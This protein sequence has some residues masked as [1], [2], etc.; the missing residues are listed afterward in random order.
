MSSTPERADLDAFRASIGDLAQRAEPTPMADGERVT[1]AKRVFAERIGVGLA[2]N[3]ESCIHCGMCAEVCHFYES[4]QDPQYAPVRKFELLR[5]Y[6]RRELSPLHWFYKLFVRDITAADLERWQ[7][8]VYDA[9]TACGR[10]DMICPMGIGISETVRVMREALAAAGLVPDELRALDQEQQ[11]HGTLFGVGADDLRRVAAELQR[12]GIDIPIDRERADVMVLTSALNLKLFQ[13]SLAATAKIMGAAGLDW[14][15]RSAAFDANNYGYLS[16]NHT[17]ER[18]EVQRVVD[19]AVACGASVVV[20]PECGHS[21]PALRWEGGNE[22][23]HKLPFQVL[24]I[25]ELIARE[26]TAGRLRVQPIGKSKKVTFHD[27]CRMGRLGGLLNEP[28]AA[29]AALDVDLREMESHGRTNFC[30][31]G[32]EGVN[33]IARAAP[34]RQR[35]FAVKQQEIDATGAD[36]VVTSCDSCRYNFITGGENAH[37]D[38]PVES[39]VELV[40]DHLQT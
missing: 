30:C 31:G 21:Y 35:A 15:M 14:T 40:A 20:V 7:P 9:C 13:R 16:G 8:L 5:R 11:Q 36:S 33:W 25:S 6:Y 24:A 39:L 38:K 29:L 27:P 4:T 32:G 2:M 28:R 34:L 26:L 18:A 37:W 19:A 1:Q 17:A 23:G 22:L 10:C 12:E 3:L